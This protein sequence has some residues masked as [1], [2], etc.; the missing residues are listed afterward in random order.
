MTL[1]IETCSKHLLALPN[2]GCMYPNHTA[3]II[4]ETAYHINVPRG[5]Q[6]SMGQQQ[7]KLKPCAAV[8]DKKEEQEGLTDGVD[9]RGLRHGAPRARR[10][11]ERY[12]PPYILCWIKKWPEKCRGGLQVHAPGWRVRLPDNAW[13]LALARLPFLRICCWYSL[14]KALHIA[15]T[16]TSSLPQHMRECCHFFNS[17]FFKK[18]TE[19][20]PDRKSGGSTGGSG[21][22]TLASTGKDSAYKHGFE[23]VRK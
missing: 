7:Q 18:L 22:R 13:R 3:K 6:R 20:G 2:H 14:L 17:F 10:V 23:R 15:C 9:L 8:E 19:K 1:D 4:Y 12:R 11:P 21:G 5:L 16:G